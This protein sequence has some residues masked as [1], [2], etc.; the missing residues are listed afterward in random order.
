MRPSILLALGMCSPSSYAQT[1]NHA[2]PASVSEAIRQ[3]G[4][5]IEASMKSS[6]VPGASV[7]I[8]YRDKVVYLKGFGTRKVG[9]NEPVNEDTVFQLASMSKPISSTVVSS[10]VSKGLLRWD[11]KIS[12]LDPEF[13]M[14]TPWVTSQLTLI[15]CFSHRSGLPGSAGNELEYYGFDRA[16]ILSRLQYLSPAYSF[17]AGYSYSNFCLTEGGVAAARVTGKSWEEVAEQ[18]LFNP[19]GMNNTSARYSDFIRH[20]NRA[21]LH[22]RFEGTWTNLATRIPDAQAPAGGVSSSARDLGNW[23]RLELAHGK[24]DGKQVIGSEALRQTHL[25]WV[26][27]NAG[28]PEPPSFYGL[29]WNYEYGALGQVRWGHAGAFSAGARTVVTLIPS[30]DL[31]IIVLS[32]AFPTGLPEAI[33]DT[34]L[35]T[36]FIGKPREDWLTHWDKAFA[37]FSEMDAQQTAKYTKPPTDATPALSNS[38]YVGTYANAFV[39]EVQV[40]E[41]DGGLALIIGPKKRSYALKH[42]SRDQFVYFSTPELPKTGLGI[43]FSIGPD[44]KAAS[45]DLEDFEGIGHGVLQRLGS[46]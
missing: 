17:R 4:P 8:V 40:I 26:Y 24:F 33:S 5:Y 11:S 39:G 9:K 35:D 42:Y 38:V 43:R 19:I 13:K 16:D 45:I 6:G 37:A 10:L 31:G 21:A 23:M 41:K 1:Q 3:L 25:P 28:S 27:R 44:G 36:V 29:G 46:Q 7:V 22:V 30:E 18:E 32:N 20:D 14:N 34:F 12:D 15:D 2:S